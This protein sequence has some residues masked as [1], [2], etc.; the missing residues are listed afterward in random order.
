MIDGG[1]IV[2]DGRPSVLW[3]MRQNREIFSR[4]QAGEDYAGS[5]DISH[6]HTPQPGNLEAPYA[7]PRLLHHGDS[8][9]TPSPLVVSLVHRR[10]NTVV[11]CREIGY[12]FG[13]ES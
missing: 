4:L 10:C 3:G 7:R 13:A 8:R 1:V 9:Y 2:A 12:R 6:P 11:P 5:L